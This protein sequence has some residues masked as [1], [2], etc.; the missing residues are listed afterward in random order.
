MATTTVFSRRIYKDKLE[1]SVVN[2]I[3]AMLKVVNDAKIKA[4]ADQMYHKRK[5]SDESLQKCAK[6][7]RL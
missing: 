6:S 4:Y 7:P 3:Q 1:P 2:H 5:E